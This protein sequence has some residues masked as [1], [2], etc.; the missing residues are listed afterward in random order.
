[1]HEHMRRR[2]AGVGASAHSP[3]H[4]QQG[5]AAPAGSRPFYDGSIHAANFVGPHGRFVVA[6]GSDNGHRMGIWDWRSGHL[7]AYVDRHHRQQ[8]A[9]T[10]THTR[11]RAHAHTH[12]HTHTHNTTQHHT[13]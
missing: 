7:L 5:L 6:C 9:S 1:M 13:G 3:F 12:T 8:P 11:A 4:E 2:Q 10:H